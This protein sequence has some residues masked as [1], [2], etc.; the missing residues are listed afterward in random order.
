MMR[1][2][3]PTFWG[4]PTSNDCSVQDNISLAPTVSQF[5]TTPVNVMSC[6]L[7]AV[8]ELARKEFKDN[9]L[10]KQ[11]FNRSLSKIHPPDGR[12]SRS[13]GGSCTRGQGCLFFLCLNSYGSW[14]GQFLTKVAANHLK[15]P[16]TVWGKEVGSIWSIW[17]ELS[18]QPFFV[19]GEGPQCKCIIMKL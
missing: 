18:W 17:S 6:S 11:G 2:A 7:V 12:A 8:L 1:E 4:Q 10:S 9:L 13:N 19:R 14:L 16:S 5:R 15:S 3:M